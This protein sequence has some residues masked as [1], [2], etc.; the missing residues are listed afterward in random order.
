MGNAD[1]PQNGTSVCQS[2]NPFRLKTRIQLG[3]YVI[4]HKGL[5]SILQGIRIVYNIVRSAT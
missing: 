4:P 5:R 3:F 2:V 1:S